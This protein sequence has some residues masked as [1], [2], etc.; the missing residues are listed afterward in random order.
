[1]ARLKSSVIED[2]VDYRLVPSLDEDVHDLR[3]LALIG[4]AVMRVMG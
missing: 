3:G 4:A 2:E 1:M